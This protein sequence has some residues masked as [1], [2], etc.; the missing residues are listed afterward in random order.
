MFVTDSQ[1]SSV[2]TLRILS[3]DM[4]YLFKLQ[5]IE[6]WGNYFV[7]VE[8]NRQN[9]TSRLKLAYPLR[10]CLKYHAVETFICQPLHCFLLLCLCSLT[11]TIYST[12][13]DRLPLSPTFADR[14]PLLP[15]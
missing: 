6:F 8:A 14:L 9:P 12:F 15:S 10:L 1:N 13:A 4:S 3:F 2:T 7:F 11:S 5:T